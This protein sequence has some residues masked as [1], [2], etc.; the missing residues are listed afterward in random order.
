MQWKMLILRFITNG[1]Q[2][3]SVYVP[4]WV[5][6]FGATVPTTSETWIPMGE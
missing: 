4:V 5:N 6:I 3:R 2:K 1:D